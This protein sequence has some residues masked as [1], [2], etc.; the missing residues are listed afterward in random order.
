[1]Q[2]PYMLKRGSA[3]LMACYD[4]YEKQVFECTEEVFLA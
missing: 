1:M 3:H 4:V 2:Y